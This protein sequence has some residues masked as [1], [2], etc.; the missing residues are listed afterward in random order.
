MICLETVYN[1]AH[2]C[3]YRRLRKTGIRQSPGWV[4]YAIRTLL[5]HASDR[6]KET[7]LHF[8]ID[9]PEPH[10]SKALL[11]RQKT[12]GVVSGRKLI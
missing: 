6:Q 9:K 11:L 2:V 12:S 3:I 1:Q 4:H 8:F 7:D 5:P 10:I